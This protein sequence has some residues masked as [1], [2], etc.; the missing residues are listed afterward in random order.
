MVDER[1][2]R[3]DAIITDIRMPGVSGADLVSA[4]SELRLRR[5]TVLA[6]ITGEA[7]IE[8]AGIVDTYEPDYF[9]RKPFDVEGLVE[10]I[11]DHVALN[12]SN[13]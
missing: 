7:N 2:S 13:V 10:K 5:G 3:F 9:F 8:E 1:K 6:V 4:L 11:V 12:R